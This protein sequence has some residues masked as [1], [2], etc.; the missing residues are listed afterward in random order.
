MRVLLVDDDANLRDLFAEFLH[1]DGH[2][3]TTAVDGREG[4]FIFRK[5]EPEFELVISDWNMPWMNGFQLVTE[6][7]HL[8]PTVKAL[9]MSGDPSNKAPEGI[10][11]LTKPFRRAELS[12]AIA[13]LS[14]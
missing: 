7:L 10:P 3:V 14:Q 13:R 8:Q 1:M 11:L 6:C 2:E 4:I 12:E 5:A 9:M